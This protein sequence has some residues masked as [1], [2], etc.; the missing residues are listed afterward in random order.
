MFKWPGVPRKICPEDPRGSLNV[1]FVYVKVRIFKCI[2]LFTFMYLKKM[3]LTIYIYTLCIYIYIFKR[4]HIFQDWCSVL[5]P[6]T[7]VSLL[8]MSGD[9]SAWACSF[10]AFASFHPLL[11]IN[12]VYSNIGT[13]RQLTH[14]IPHV[15]LKA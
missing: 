9:T 7:G 14:Q 10:D 5:E 15:I 13:Q 8:F 2:C 6:H 12:A 3:Y 11:H 1:L 4:Y